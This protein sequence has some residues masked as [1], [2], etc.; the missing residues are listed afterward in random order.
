ML[1]NRVSDDFYLLNNQVINDIN[2]NNVVLDFLSQILIK[3]NLT[4]HAGFE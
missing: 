3:T 4:M 1:T 2:T